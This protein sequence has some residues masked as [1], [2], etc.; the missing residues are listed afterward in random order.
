[1]DVREKLV[2][3]IE[4][5]GA[6]FECFP[7]GDYEQEQIEKI[8]DHLIAHGVTVQGNTEIS[9]ELLERLRKAPITVMTEET[10][11]EVVQEWISVKD[12]LPEMRDDGFADA[13]LV[14]DGSLAHIAYFVDGEWIFTDNGQMKEPMFYDVTHWQ[15]LP[16]PPKGE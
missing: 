8:A 15:Y 4:Q 7:V 6:C 1:M 16:Q 9:D 14:T 13:F 12:R 3:L 11:G 2:E 10:S 5:S